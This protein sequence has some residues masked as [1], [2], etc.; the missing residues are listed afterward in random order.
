MSKLK[1]EGGKNRAERKK[2]NQLPYK[3]Q[4]LLGPTLQ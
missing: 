2:N 3:K 4:L 1:G